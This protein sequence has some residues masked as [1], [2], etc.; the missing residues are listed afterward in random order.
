MAS[1]FDQCY[2]CGALIADAEQHEK[3]HL[4]IGKAILKAQH[5]EATEDQIDTA[6]RHL[7]QTESALLEAKA[8]IDAEKEPADPVARAV[9]NFLGRPDS[10][11]S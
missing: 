4:N 10:S 8:K 9:M 2:G 3:W 11:G 6:V 1:G 5:P 7:A